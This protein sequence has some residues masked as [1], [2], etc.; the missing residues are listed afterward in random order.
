[1][2]DPEHVIDYQS[3]EVQEDVSYEEEPLCILDRKEN[4]LRTWTIPYVKV[5]WQRHSPEEATW[6]LQ[7][8][9]QQSYPYLFI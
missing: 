4:V 9:M 3:L 1:M 7:E 2:P 5:Q 8:K 6:E